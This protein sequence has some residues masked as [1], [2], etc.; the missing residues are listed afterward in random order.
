MISFLSKKLLELFQLWNAAERDVVTRQC[1]DY[2]I[3]ALMTELRVGAVANK[4]AVKAFHLTG[5]KFF[6]QAS[7]VPAINF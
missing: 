2:A 5:N 3:N 1:S 7:A 4:T 6:H